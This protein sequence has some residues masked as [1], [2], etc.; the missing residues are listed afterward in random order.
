MRKTGYVNYSRLPKSR[1]TEELEFWRS[2]EE[3]IIKG[4]TIIYN[5]IGDEFLSRFGYRVTKK[6]M[7]DKRHICFNE[8]GIAQIIRK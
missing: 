6:Y 8:S 2:V 1:L 4:E 3:M 5:Y 7:C